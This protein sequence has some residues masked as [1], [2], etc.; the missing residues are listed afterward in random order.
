MKKA[1]IT[2]DKKKLNAKQKGQRGSEMHDGLQGE[3]VKCM[4]DCKERE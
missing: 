3:G 4:M 2:L 1:T